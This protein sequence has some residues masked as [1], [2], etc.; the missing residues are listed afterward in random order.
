MKFLILRDDRGSE[1]GL[2][3]I[4]KIESIF[5]ITPR[6]DLGEKWHIS[7]NYGG[8]IQRVHFDSEEEAQR[9]FK[10]IMTDLIRS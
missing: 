5:I 7:I 1:I 9:N 6:L 4:E 3:Q 8:L 2:I 10:N